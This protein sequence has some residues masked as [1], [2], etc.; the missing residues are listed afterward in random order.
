MGQIAE[1]V[2]TDLLQLAS[3]T[4]NYHLTSSIQLKMAKN[5]YVTTS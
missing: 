2:K 5:K 1:N 3:I 4:I